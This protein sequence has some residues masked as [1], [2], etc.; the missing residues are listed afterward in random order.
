MLHISL[1][2]S[3]EGRWI[4]IAAVTITGLMK[5]IL[6]DGFNLKLFYISGAILFWIVFILLKYRKNHNVLKGWGFQR[7]H[8]KKSMLYLLPF[9]ILTSLI[10]IL[11]G[12]KVNATFL[13]WH[14]IPILIIYPL[15]GLIQQFMMIGLI[16][17]NLKIIFSTQLSLSWV[18]LI[19]SVAFTLV[20]IPTYP[21]MIYAFFMEFIFAYAYFKWKNLWSLGLIHGW[22]AGLL[23]FFVL[24]RDIWNELFMI[25]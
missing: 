20:H 17:S 16:A 24:E 7:E 13:N 21:V 12:I 6:V 1:K 15:W 22:V 10:I 11:Y 23:Y 8:F 4:E 19:T 25:F 2:K 14:I 9:A 5:F 18:I 3:L